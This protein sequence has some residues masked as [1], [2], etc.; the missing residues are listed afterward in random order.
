MGM[1]FVA[2]VLDALSLSSVFFSS[3]PVVIF[4]S[5]VQDECKRLRQSIRCG[6]T[7]RLTVV[8]LLVMLCYM[9]CSRYLQLVLRRIFVLGVS[10]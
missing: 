5:C 9:L 2:H 10:G 3:F 8:G 1:L 4:Y 7:K 6:L